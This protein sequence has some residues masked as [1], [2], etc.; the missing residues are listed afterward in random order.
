MSQYKISKERLTQIIKEEYALI[1]EEHSARQQATHTRKHNRAPA[2]LPTTAA[3][4]MDAIRRL[5]H[6]ELQSL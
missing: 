4:S 2:G 5:I 3:N 1:L 6:D